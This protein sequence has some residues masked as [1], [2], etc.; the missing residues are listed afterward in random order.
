MSF[1]TVVTLFKTGRLT[2]EAAADMLVSRLGYGN[3][4]RAYAVLNT[5][6]KAF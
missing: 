4:A 6:R 2:L 3:R 1:S 5:A